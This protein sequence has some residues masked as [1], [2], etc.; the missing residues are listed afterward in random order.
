MDT[1]GGEGKVLPGLG[2]GGG[3]GIVSSG[4]GTRGNAGATGGPLPPAGLPERRASYSAI[5][6]SAFF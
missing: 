1:A 6:S 2:G 5:F 3:G 4:E